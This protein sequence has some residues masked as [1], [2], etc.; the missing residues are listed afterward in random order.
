L[1]PIVSANGVGIQSLPDELLLRIAK[2][3]FMWEPK[4]CIRSFAYHANLPCILQPS[5]TGPVP[6]CSSASNPRQDRDAR[7]SQIKLRNILQSN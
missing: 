3:L 1:K 7:R 2:E 4:R 6:Q 5:P